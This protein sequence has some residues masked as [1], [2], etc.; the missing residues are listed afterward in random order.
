[1]EQT[2]VVKKAVVVILSIFWCIFGA[3][4]FGAFPNPCSIFFYTRGYFWYKPVYKHRWI[5][6]TNVVATA[7]YTNLNGAFLFYM[8]CNMK[9]SGTNLYNKKISK[10]F[11]TLVAVRLKGIFILVHNPL[12]RALSRFSDSL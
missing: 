5:K 7:F 9:K 3:L 11:Q 8:W 1:L 12:E 4:F 2:R 6:F 10:K